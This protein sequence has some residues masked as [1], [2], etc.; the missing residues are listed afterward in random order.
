MAEL[1]KDAVISV[2]RVNHWEM[3]NNRM[4]KT[5]QVLRDNATITEKDLTG[6]LAET[7]EEEILLASLEVI[8]V[9]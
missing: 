4:V 3:H 8:E 5:R 2:T 1:D 9:L 7:L 6:S